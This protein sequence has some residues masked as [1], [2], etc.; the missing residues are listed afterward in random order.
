MAVITT[1]S[2]LMGA[3]VVSG[4]VERGEVVFVFWK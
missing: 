3:D 4:G 1:K 2:R